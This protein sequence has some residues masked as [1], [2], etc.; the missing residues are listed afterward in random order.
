MKHL[1]MLFAVIVMAI[2]SQSCDET[3]P[4]SNRVLA[5]KQEQIM[6]EANKQVGMPAVPNFQ[7]R[8]IMKMIYELRD[9]EDL[10]CYCYLMNEINGTVGQFLG[11]CVGYGLPYA[12]QYTNP[13]VADSWHGYSEGVYTLPQADPNGLFMPASAEATWILLI[14]PNTNEPHPVYIEPKIIVSPFP[15]K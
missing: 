10:I 12:T 11:K 7:E 9:R 5:N 3:Q 1:L 6:V 2:F 8:K 4:D 15:L 13:E 14:D